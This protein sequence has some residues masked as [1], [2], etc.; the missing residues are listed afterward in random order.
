MEPI[1]KQPSDIEIH[2]RH[3]LLLDQQ[4]ADLELELARLPFKISQVKFFRDKTRELLD[5]ATAQAARREV[6]AT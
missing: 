2:E 5:A 4:I 1:Q 6:V 3:L